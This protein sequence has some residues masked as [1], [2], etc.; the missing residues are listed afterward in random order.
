MELAVVWRN[1][2]PPPE[3]D[4]IVTR[5]VDYNSVVIYEVTSWEGTQNFMLI[6]GA[7]A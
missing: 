6:S 3:G 5:V 1:P 7:V 2:E 4:Q